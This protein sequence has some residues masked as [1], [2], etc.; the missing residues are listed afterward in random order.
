MSGFIPGRHFSVV[1]CRVL[2]RELAAMA[3]SLPH[4]YEL[5]FLRQGL[6]LTPDLLRSELQAAIDEMSRGTLVGAPA[7]EAASSWTSFSSARVKPE[8]V[9]IG[10]GLCSNGLVGIEARDVTLIAPK[11]HD[12]ITFFLGSKE[13]YRTVFDD[14]PGTY[15]YSPGWIETGTQPGRERTEKLRAEYMAKY[16]EENAD[17][18]MDMEQDW[19]KKYE[20]CSYVSLGGFDDA[21]Y[22]A[23]SKDSADFLGW[24]YREFEG[25]DSLVRAFLTG[26]WSEERF[27]I[28]PPGEKIAA[29]FDEGILRLE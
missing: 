17:Y 12:C 11:A 15:W 1:A 25:D 21:A 9:L 2:W 23:Y 24:N 10:Y 18:L 8:A 5:H 22:R 3:A 20:S 29:S 7:G 28:V 16:G 14:H 26:E 19:M 13:R 6:H 27:L 4:S